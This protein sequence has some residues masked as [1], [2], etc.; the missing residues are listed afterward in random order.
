MQFSKIT[1]VG[2]LKVITIDHP[3]K[4][5][6][7]VDAFIIRGPNDKVWYLFCD[8]LLI[9]LDQ[10]SAYSRTLARRLINRHFPYLL[11]K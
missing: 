2:S 4:N 3:Q 11:E 8:G 10:Y 7:T 9:P 5:H 1:S 6:S